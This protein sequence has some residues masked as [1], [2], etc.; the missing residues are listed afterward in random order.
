M[1]GSRPLRLT[2]YLMD[3]LKAGVIWGICYFCNLISDE[4]AQDKKMNL[5]V[6]LKGGLFW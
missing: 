1:G 5:S 6:F 2:P 3:I 4:G